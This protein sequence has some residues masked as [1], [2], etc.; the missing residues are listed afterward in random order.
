MFLTDPSAPD[1]FIISA[2]SDAVKGSP[3]PSIVMVFVTTSAGVDVCLTTWVVFVVCDI[4]LA[5]ILTLRV[6]TTGSPKQK[7]IEKCRLS[8]DYVKAVHSDTVS[9]GTCGFRKHVQDTIK[10][11]RFV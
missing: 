1:M 3:S 7:Q 10:A 9:F 6:T 8:H 2:S 11:M 4:G 5:S